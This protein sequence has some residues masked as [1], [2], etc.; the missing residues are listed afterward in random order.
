MRKRPRT[1]PEARPY[2][3]AALAAAAVLLFVLAPAIAG[4]PQ[5]AGGASRFLTPRDVP[6]KPARTIIPRDH[7]EEILH[8]KLR[9]GAMVRLRG[10]RFISLGQDDLDDLNAVLGGIPGLR[11]ERLFSRAED[12][13]AREK[14]RIEAR[15]GREQADKNLYYRLRT[16]GEVDLARL[17]DHLN[18]LDIV[19]IAYAE[20]LPAPPPVTPDFSSTQVYLNAAPDGIDAN[21]A[22]RV[23]GGRGS[24]VR[25]TDVEYSWNQS[26]E[27]LGSAASALIPNK[28]P[29][30]PFSDFNH[31]TAVLGEM[32][33]GNNGFGVTGIVHQAE[34]RLV[35]A[36]NS[37]D[38]YDLADSIDLAHSNSS[39]GD[40]I[41]IEQQTSGPNGC[42]PNTQ[43]GCVAVEWVKA[44]Y[45]AV[46]AATSDGVNVVEAAGNGA[47]DL[48]DTST[49]GNPFPD[50]R[51][52]SGAIIVG[53]GA[54]TCS[55]HPRGRLG[56]SNFGPRVNLQGW[57]QCVVTTGY[58][59][60]QGGPANEHYTDSFGGTS[61]ASPIVTGAAA[62]LSS[63]AQTLTGMAPSPATIRSVLMSTGTAQN[64][65]SGTLS[66]NIGPLPN[67]KK[68]LA[69][70]ETQAP[71]LTCPA[72]IVAEC[73]SPAGVPVLYTPTVTDNCDPIP[74][75]SCAPP[76]GSTFPI[77]V[78]PTTCNASDAVENKSTC[79][80]NVTVQDTAPPVLICPADIVVECTG[81]CGIDASDPN[82]AGF[83]G[84]VA[85]TDVCDTT[86]V[87]VHN[88]PPF[89]NLGSTPVTFMA[90]D[91]AGN[92]SACTRTVTVVDTIPPIMTVVLSRDV[93]WPPNHKLADI[94]ATVAVS[95]I[96]DPNAS[97]VLTSITSDEPDNGLGDGDQAP[98][99]TD[100]NFGTPD[101]SFRLRSER[102]GL[103]DGRVYTITY[104]ASDKSGNTTVVTAEVRVSHDGPAAALAA[105]G[106][107]ATGT[108]L[109]SGTK[110][111][112]LVVPSSAAFDATAV[113]P[114][115]AMVG[116][117]RAAI[118]A[119]SHRLIDRTGDGLPDLELTYLAKPVRD[120][121]ATSDALNPVGLHF[122]VGPD[123]GDYLA[124][125]IF[126]LGLRLKSA[127][128]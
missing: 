47:Q 126:K 108:G 119:L 109:L 102:G 82:L 67:L 111:I 103:G 5:Q 75:S 122:D 20:P 40:V 115:D 120:L 117:T 65:G 10:G 80:F 90:T 104:T 92:V 36:N 29:A 15:S 55:A 23:C 73:T 14:R 22:T 27:D 72:N 44:Y 86:P 77:G 56:F 2:H 37:E 6:E 43:V 85:A 57:G 123:T 95:D 13:L 26:H 46:V 107:N 39:D 88:A 93:L 32:I 17:I 7:S 8:L 110:T 105:E 127:T 97:F 51:A 11:I 121:R 68:A 114:A 21:L 71:T 124:L 12:V 45:D 18:A 35:N 64:T 116:N 25:V 76:S 70:Y 78:T 66:G 24:A 48:G 16:R 33:S 1:D 54:G 4:G 49:Y 53:A 87:I 50:G 61:S 101:T 59:D 30:D 94:T 96:C 89:F 9:E 91:G 79:T 99:F 60:L 74:S 125:D 62:S 112:R 81:N 83:F 34:I 38:G 63:A 52:N 106:F 42:D 19:E 84:S 41:L 98:D 3:R 100:A 31:G 69:T 28:T 118:R 113:D 58:G 128:N